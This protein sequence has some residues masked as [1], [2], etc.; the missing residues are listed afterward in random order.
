MDQNPF[1]PGFGKQPPLLVGRRGLTD[2]FWAAIDTGPQS[3]DY[4]MVLTGIRGS[5]KT[6]FM[7]SVR[8]AARQR[9][10]GVIKATSVGNDRLEASIRE[11]ALQ[12]EA[13]PHRFL[14]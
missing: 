10:W 2:R 3:D 14:G 12:Q 8:D 13:Q 7:G 5:G 4:A 1:R 9:G 11:R 6:A